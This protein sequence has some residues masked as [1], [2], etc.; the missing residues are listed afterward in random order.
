MNTEKL[1][2]RAAA[3]LTSKAHDIPAFRVTIG[4]D[5]FVDAIV[6]VVDKRQSAEKYTRVPT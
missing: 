3:L 2:Q 4:L 6:A 5:G 1:S